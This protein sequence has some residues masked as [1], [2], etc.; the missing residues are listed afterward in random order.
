MLTGAQIPN[1]VQPTMCAARIRDHV[2]AYYLGPKLSF[3]PHAENFGAS[4]AANKCLTREYRDP[5][6]EREHV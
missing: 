1:M 3:D 4:T 5:F 2:A 6:F